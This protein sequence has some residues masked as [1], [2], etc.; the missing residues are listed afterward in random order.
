[1]GARH[2]SPGTHAVRAK[3][4]TQVLG[5]VTKELPQDLLAFLVDCSQCL[6]DHGA[7]RPV[8]AL[9]TRIVLAMLLGDPVRLA[10][11]VE[12]HTRLRDGAGHSHVD[13][14]WLAA[15][16]RTRHVAGTTT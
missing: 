3:L 5:C 15:P 8:G 1:Q 16:V 12:A 7:E 4:A 2:A 6:E 13:C 10:R 11:A 9:E 14:K